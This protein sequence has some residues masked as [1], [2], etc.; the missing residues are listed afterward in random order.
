MIVDGNRPLFKKL[1]LDCLR[2][3]PDL[4][5]VLHFAG[6]GQDDRLPER[7]VLNK[8]IFL[9][10]GP[11]IVLT[12]GDRL[13]TRM[14][15]AGVIIPGHTLVVDETGSPAVPEDQAVVRGCIF[16]RRTGAGG[17]KVR[18]ER[19]DPPAS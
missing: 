14:L 10:Y 4:R 2:H 19:R 7:K 17:E 1:L 8:T 16:R 13:V 15:I 18:S 3:I 9:R 5:Q 6:T 11:V 12:V